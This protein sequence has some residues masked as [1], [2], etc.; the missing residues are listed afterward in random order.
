[1]TLYQRI[2]DYFRVQKSI[3]NVLLS[4]LGFLPKIL[5][6]KTLVLSGCLKFRCLLILV[7]MVDEHM[8]KL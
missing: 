1:M 8:C 2:P 3:A 5:L 4:H 6:L 7:L